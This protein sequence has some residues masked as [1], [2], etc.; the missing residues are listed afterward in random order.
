MSVW[1]RKAQREK[2]KVEEVRAEE[3]LLARVESHATFISQREPTETALSPVLAL[4][5]CEEVGFTTN[6]KIMQLP[7]KHIQVTL[8][9]I[10]T[11]S[12]F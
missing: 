4:N 6:D 2:K 12:V 11:W 9:I 7:L 10:S 5:F 3:P 8:Q 1:P